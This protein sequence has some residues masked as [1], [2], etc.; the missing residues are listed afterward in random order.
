MKK[1]L[2]IILLLVLSAGL[3]AKV[4]LEALSKIGEVDMDTIKNMKGFWMIEDSRFVFEYTDFFACRID[5]L[6]Y[7]VYRRNRNHTRI[8][9]V[10]TVVKSKKTGKLYFARGQYIKGRLVGSTSRIAFRGKD[11]MT[12]YKVNSQRNV[13]YKARRVQVEDQNKNK[14]S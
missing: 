2:V 10:F 7:F 5:G 8:P 3:S 1:L 14:K 6:K 4:Y 9:Y 13:F 11:K 12:V